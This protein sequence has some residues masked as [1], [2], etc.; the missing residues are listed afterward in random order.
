MEGVVNRMVINFP[1]TMFHAGERY[2]TQ[3]RYGVN[4]LT[5]CLDVSAVLWGNSSW[6]NNNNNKNRRGAD[7]KNKRRE[8]STIHKLFIRRRINSVVGLR[9]GGRSSGLGT[10]AAW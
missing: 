10:A 6:R 9:F 8:E 4:L 2:K 3:L 1:L 5:K 7:T